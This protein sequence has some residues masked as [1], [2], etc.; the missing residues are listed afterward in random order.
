MSPGQAKEEEI[1]RALEAATHTSGI[2][3]TVMRTEYHTVSW[4]EFI[5]FC[6]AGGRGAQR[7][8]RKNTRELGQNP[9][10]F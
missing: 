7:I 3:A 4:Q 5:T 9:S 10:E 6:M 2:E 1:R 8:D